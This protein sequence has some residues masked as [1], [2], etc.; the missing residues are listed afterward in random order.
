MKRCDDFMYILILIYY[1]LCNVGIIMY[2]IWKVWRGINPF[3]NCLKQKAWELI[4]SLTPESE[5][6]ESEAPANPWVVYAV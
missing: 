1:I 6:P 3:Q 2:L 4:S 5:A